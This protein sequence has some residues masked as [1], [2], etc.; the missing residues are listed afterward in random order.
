MERTEFSASYNDLI[1][2]MKEC[3]SGFDRAKAD[4]AMMGRFIDTYVPIRT[5]KELEEFL[6]ATL[7]DKSLQR[8]EDHYM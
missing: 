3:D 5:A 1:K 8:L 2:Q 7:P 6:K 4:I